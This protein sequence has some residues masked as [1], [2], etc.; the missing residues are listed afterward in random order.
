MMDYIKTYISYTYYPDMI[1][2]HGEPGILNE[3]HGANNRLLYC[4]VS[5]VPKVR[6]SARKL[7]L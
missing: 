1:L 3:M 2:I 4:Y 6:V 5:V 7:K